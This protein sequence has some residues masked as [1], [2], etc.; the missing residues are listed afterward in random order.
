MYI[1]NISMQG[2]PIKMSFNVN[3][4]HSSITKKK[5]VCLLRTEMSLCENIR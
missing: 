3:D 4:V 5:N 2:K 1:S